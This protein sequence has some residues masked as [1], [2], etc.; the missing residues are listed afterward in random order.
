MRFI[1]RISRHTH[2]SCI[3]CDLV[4]S[5]Y[6]SHRAYSSLEC[7]IV[8]WCIDIS[9]QRSL[10]RYRPEDKL[11]ALLNEAF[12][13]LELLFSCYDKDG[14]QTLMYK[15]LEQALVY[16][17]QLSGTCEEIRGVHILY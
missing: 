17:L 14:A 8:C 6:A 10:P 12:K 13:L 7:Y 16:I 3:G 4:H 2:L 15:E 1:S 5:L 11:P 9:R